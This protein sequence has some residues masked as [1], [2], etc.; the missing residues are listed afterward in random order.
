MQPEKGDPAVR[1]TSHDVADGLR[2]VGVVP[3]D[4]VF[5]H[6]SLSSMGT[7]EDG[8]DTVID[9]F[10]E[11]VGPQGT[12]GVPTL[13]NWAPEE[14][15]LVFSRWDPKTSPAY[16]SRIPEVF[17]HRPDAVRSD[18]PT[19]SVAAIGA[20]AEE[21]CANHGR[22]GPRRCIFSDTAFAHESP[23]EKLREWDAACC[24]I[25]VTLRVCTMTHWVESVVVERALAHV[26]PDRFDE[27]ASRVA[28]WMSP[29][30]WPNWPVDSREEIERQLADQGLVRYGRIGSATLR[31][32]RTRP[33]AEGWLGIVESDPQRWF[34]PDFLE[35]WQACHAL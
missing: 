21:L 28:G 20:R 27:L 22:S 23:W 14:Q 34:P 16:V 9:G 11:A 35:W 19:H 1:V 31:C 3:G 17:R 4:T 10:L 7:V 29:G 12:V 6:S 25:G 5:F 18:H 2:S 24:F 26:G 8:A 32:A 30:V 15:H 33:M 13:C